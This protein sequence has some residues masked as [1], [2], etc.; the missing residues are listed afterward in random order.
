MITFKKRINCYKWRWR[1]LTDP[2]HLSTKE[3]TKKELKKIPLRTEII[4][5]LIGSLKR[6]AL[7]LEIGV[8]NPEAN[9][10]KIQAAKKYSVDPGFDF[11]PNPVDFKLTRNKI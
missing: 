8:R 3:L 11:E 7:Y 2:Y 5:F 10:N 4:N 6:D 1:C 9:F